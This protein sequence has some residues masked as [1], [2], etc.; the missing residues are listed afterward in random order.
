MKNTC[1]YCG[2]KIDHE[3]AVVKERSDTEGSSYYYCSEEHARRGSPEHPPNRLKP[4]YSVAR[5]RKCFG[6]E[7]VITDRDEYVRCYLYHGKEVNYVPNFICLR[8]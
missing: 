2:E 5:H 1:A 3:K 6:C 7:A 8:K 4:N